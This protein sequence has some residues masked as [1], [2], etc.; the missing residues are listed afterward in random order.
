M[1]IS[2]VVVSD[3]ETQAS[4]IFINWFVIEKVIAVGSDRHS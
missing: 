2:R 1:L 3:G 4:I